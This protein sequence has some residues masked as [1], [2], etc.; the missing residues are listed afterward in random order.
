MTGKR[1]VRDPQGEEAPSRSFP[2]VFFRAHLTA[3]V[4]SALAG[5]VKLGFDIFFPPQTKF[6]PQKG[7]GEKGSW[8]R[9]GV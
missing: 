2:G 5:A 3:P 1:E 4:H 8:G 6:P 9:W 7:A